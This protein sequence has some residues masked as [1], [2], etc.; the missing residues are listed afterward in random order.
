MDRT[1][2]LSPI[3]EFGDDLLSLDRFRRAVKLTKASDGSLA[4]RVQTEDSSKSATIMLAEQ[5]M[6]ELGP[7]QP[8]F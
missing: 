8:L 3:L 2:E 5:L 1:T 4:G 6:A 7:G